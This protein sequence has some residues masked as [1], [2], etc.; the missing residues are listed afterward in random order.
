MM[1]ALPARIEK[2]RRNHKRRTHLHVI[3]AAQ[4]TR[5]L[6][7]ETEPVR[8]AAK[9]MANL[10]PEQQRAALR[11]LHDIAAPLALAAE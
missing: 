8:L 3:A 10:S 2:A 6:I 9:L 1:T 4:T 5:R 11:A 7:A